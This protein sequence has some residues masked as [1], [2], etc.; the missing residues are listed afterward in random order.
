MSINLAI[1]ESNKLGNSQAAKCPSASNVHRIL[2]DLANFNR[3]RQIEL[4]YI[5]VDDLK[6]LFI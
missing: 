1:N 2:A 3:T 5:S 4:E 6:N